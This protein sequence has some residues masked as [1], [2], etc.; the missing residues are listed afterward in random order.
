MFKQIFIALKNSGVTGSKDASVPHRFH[1]SG[2]LLVES[3]KCTECKRCAQACP[4]RALEIQGG[5]VI[6]WLCYKSSRCIGCMRC[7]E[8]CEAKCL[9]FKP[10]DEGFLT[11]PFRQE[12]R[13]LSFGGK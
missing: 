12:E 6:Q 5:E 1:A 9:A 13:L 8:A 7:I 3:S 11:R 2:K 4:V 10:T